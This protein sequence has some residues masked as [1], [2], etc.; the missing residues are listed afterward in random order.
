MRGILVS[1]LV[2]ALLGGVLLAREPVN[3]ADPKDKTI[4]EKFLVH[5][6][7][8]PARYTPERCRAVAA[9]C[10]ED[11]T[12]QVFPQVNMT[13]TA[14]E[15]SGEAKYLDMFVQTFDNMRSAM[16]KGPDGY[17][18]WYGKALST[19]QDPRNPNKK[20][21]VI[22]TSFRTVESLARFAELAGADAS[23]RR[24]Y[25]GQRAEYLALAENHLVKKWIARANY[26]DLG[27]GGAIFRTHSGLKDVKGHLTQP[28]NKHS[29]IIRALLGLYRTTGKDEYMRMAVKLGTR[30]KRSLTLKAGHY[31]WNYWDPA[32]AWDVHPGDAA[33]W[34][35]WIGVEH[36][37]GYYSSSLSQ[38]VALY[39]HGVVFDKAD[40]DRFVK[41][42]V[43]VAWNGDL[44]NPKWARCDGTTS[45]K[46]MK[47]S[48]IC[49]ALAPFHEK[50]YALL[51][52]GARQDERL[53]NAAHSWQGGPVANGWLSGKY[54]TCPA[55]KAGKQIHLEA[56]R[57][58]LKKSNN[59]ALLRSLA[60][61]VAGSGYAAPRTPKAMKPMLAEPKS[62]I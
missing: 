57:R 17:L 59:Q 7:K 37:G 6:A 43:G 32:G 47:G 20:V 40:I 51:Y 16:T 60:F 28:H 53:K 49:A 3:V 39:H 19:F 26:V 58:F 12:W 50:V 46:Y 29:I 42:Q 5:T 18:G 25:E 4:I 11:Y 36:K 13:L 10:P 22:I 62:G 31:E 15:L 33:K 56:G 55:A 34:K 38:A 44:A 52:T 61:R 41:T 54:V 23:L 1:V 27:K 21:D 14:Y 45:A 24:K 8:V 30:Y 35:H 9:K 48:Y 2:V